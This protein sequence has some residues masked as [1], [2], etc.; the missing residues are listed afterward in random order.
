MQFATITIQLLLIF[1]LV[2]IKN[3]QSK[4][5]RPYGKTGISPKN[6]IFDSGCENHN[7]K[8]EFISSS[9][10][11]YETDTDDDSSGFD[12]NENDYDDP[13]E[14]DTWSWVYTFKVIP[15]Y[16]EPPYL[17]AL[18]MDER[19]LDRVNDCLEPFEIVVKY[20]EK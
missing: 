1:N 12:D 11:C 9:V 8:I 13:A 20:D 15:G 7:F 16:Q 4:V 10:S 2:F 5:S 19:N 17:R 18:L 6:K 3:A 14:S